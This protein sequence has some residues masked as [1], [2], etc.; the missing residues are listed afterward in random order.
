MLLNERS[1]TL[2]VWIWSLAKQNNL[3]LSKTKQKP[4]HSHSIFHSHS[5]VKTTTAQQFALTI[6]SILVYV[7][8]CVCM[9]FD[10]FS[11]S[12]MIGFQTWLHWTKAICLA[13]GRQRQIENEF[14]GIHSLQTFLPFVVPS[15]PII[16]FIDLMICSATGGLMDV[17]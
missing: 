14:T 16:N 12:I 8:V 7:F 1:H 10:R 15:I 13:E 11:C 17:A 6:K 4:K 9:C 2:N 5:L 3:I